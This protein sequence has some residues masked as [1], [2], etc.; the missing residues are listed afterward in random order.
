MSKIKTTIVGER[1]YLINDLLLVEGISRAGKFLLANILHG[2]KGIEPTQYCELLEQIPYLEKFN[3]IANKA[4]RELLRAEVDINGYKM[5]IGRN[6]NHRKLDKSAIFNNPRYKQYLKRSAIKD[7]KVILRQFYQAR[8]YNPFIVHEIMPAIS[9]Y[10]KTF[11]RIKVV[12]IQRSPLDLVY[13]HYVWYLS[14]K[15]KFK[16]T[17]WPLAILL[18]QGNNSIP[19]YTLVYQRSKNNKQLIDNIILAIARLLAD[20]QSTY[21]SLSLLNKKKFL[22]VRYEDILVNPHEV[23]DKI[24]KF[25]KREVL[26]EMSKI[27]K[28][29]KLPNKEYNNL[30][31]EKIKEIKAIAS[32]ECF[33]HLLKIETQYIK[34][35]KYD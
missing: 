18:R 33:N 17:L 32:P 21:K 6:F 34:N 27:I 23:I 15:K 31:E 19:W 1:P 12:S 24:S 3:L 14:Y 30:K 8:P 16:K 5:L 20:Y 26:P 22:F 10:L 7:T 13:S 9:I 28:A 11:P 4:A 35:K 29:E 2:F 25:L